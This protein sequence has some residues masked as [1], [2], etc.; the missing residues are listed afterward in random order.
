LS[1]KAQ[2]PLLGGKRRVPY[3]AINVDEKITFIL[4]FVKKPFLDNVSDQLYD[5]SRLAK[6]LPGEESYAYTI[7]NH[8]SITAFISLLL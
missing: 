1:R 4:P 3:I 6:P 5:L 7:F 8:T 2:N